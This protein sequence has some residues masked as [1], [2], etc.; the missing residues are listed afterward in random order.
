MGAKKVTDFQ[1]IMEDSVLRLVVDHVLRYQKIG[2]FLPSETSV[3]KIA[4]ASALASGL[5]AL[6]KSVTLVGPEHVPSSG[7]VL[8]YVDQIAPL[9][10][11]TSHLVV[12][13]DTTTTAL[14]QLSY[15][16][17]PGKVRIFLRPKEGAF[18]PHDVTV[19]A[20]EFP[21]DLIILSG[22][23]QP[24]QLGRVFTDNVELFYSLPRI[25]IDVHPANEAYGT[26]NIVS[27][28]ASSVSELAYRVLVAI[29]E[30][31]AIPPA[32]TALVTGILDATAHLQGERTTRDTFAVVAD[33]VAA[34]AEYRAAVQVP[35]EARRLS[36]V[37]LYGRIL[38]RLHE[39][40][41]GR[42][43][44][45]VIQEHD[46]EKTGERAVDAASIE[47]RI[48]REVPGVALVLLAIPSAEGVRLH[49]MTAHELEESKIGVLFPGLTWRVERLVGYAYATAILTS[50]EQPQVLDALLKSGTEQLLDAL[51]L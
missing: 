18:S 7:V 20:A 46:L 9:N 12:Q 32:A 26:I 36:Q 25:N 29:D 2:I 22:V 11:D 40:G 44:Y 10:I 38:A 17:E 31:V 35:A 51:H 13:L 19:Q 15:E 14:G 27:V 42:G 5:T 16:T 23:Q 50:G 4:A 6:G 1:N 24:E 28:A 3:D 8:P 37:Q 48:L 39:A 45:A 34:G 41:E 21:F 33:L 49:I 43:L 30:V 47:T